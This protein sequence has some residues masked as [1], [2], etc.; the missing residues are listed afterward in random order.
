MRKRSEPLRQVVERYGSRESEIAH[1][2][3][4]DDDGTLCIAI[5]I[6]DDH[7]ER[8][9][10]EVEQPVTPRDGLVAPR[11]DDDPARARGIQRRA[12]ARLDVHIRRTA[13]RLATPR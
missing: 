8:L 1:T 2:A 11:L 12:F 4:F 3:P 9:I 13:T 7:I 6:G 10:H 5:D